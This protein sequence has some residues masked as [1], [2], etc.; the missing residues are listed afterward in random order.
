MVR[1]LAQFFAREFGGIVRQLWVVVVDMKKKTAGVSRQTISVFR[2]LSGARCAPC[3]N[4]RISIVRVDL[5]S[6]VQLQAIE[7]VGEVLAILIKEISSGPG[8]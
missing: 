5:R 2:L 4:V 1:S 8:N 3:A 6:F 7:E